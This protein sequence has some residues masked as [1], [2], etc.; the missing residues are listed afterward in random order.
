VEAPAACSLQLVPLLLLRVM[1]V[2][3]V[4]VMLLRLIAL[5]EVR[6]DRAVVVFACGSTA[7]QQGHQLGWLGGV[8]EPARSLGRWPG[9]QSLGKRRTAAHLAAA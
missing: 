1:M 3:V 4:L 9:S 2:L 5:V 6:C 8:G 7:Q